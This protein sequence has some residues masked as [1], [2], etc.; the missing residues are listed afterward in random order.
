ML[1]TLSQLPGNPAD[2]VQTADWTKLSASLPA[3]RTAA[4]VTELFYPNQDVDQ[5]AK[6]RGGFLVMLDDGAYRELCERI[7][8]TPALQ[9]I[10]I[11][12]LFRTS[13]E[14]GRFMVQILGHVVAWL[15]P[16]PT[17][18]LDRRDNNKP[19]LRKDLLPALQDC[20]SRRIQAAEKRLGTFVWGS[21][22]QRG[23]DTASVLLQQEV[24]N[25]ARDNIAAFK[26]PATKQYFD[27]L[28]GSASGQQ[29]AQRF[30]DETWGGVLTIVREFLGDDFQP[31]WIASPPDTYSSRETGLEKQPADLIQSL[32]ALIR[33]SPE[34]VQ[35]PALNT[36]RASS[37]LEAA[38]VRWAVQQCRLA[39]RDWENGS[40]P[41]WPADIAQFVRSAQ[42]KYEKLLFG[43]TDQSIR[44]PEQE[45]GR[46]N[47]EDNSDSEPAD[48]PVRDSGSVRAVAGPKTQPVAARDEQ[49][50]LCKPRRPLPWR[51]I[52]RTKLGNKDGRVAQ[53]I[54]GAR[55][56]SPAPSPSQESSGD[57]K[58]DGQETPGMEATAVFADV[59]R[60]PT[61]TSRPSWRQGPIAV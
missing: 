15:N 18:A 42:H 51:K 11:Q 27:Q 54:P 21:E 39:R 46:L 5:A 36:T 33:N 41:S 55:Q 31:T 34:V 12:G 2:T 32:C 13:K 24:L 45:G 35:N 49:E 26:S 1:C 50:Y 30:L 28:P 20:P 52:D 25:F 3:N 7:L 40:G 10:D 43:L 16:N 6:R 47:A 37:A 60:P 58:P 61:R 57:Q 23:A 56:G 44:Q 59:P 9:F 48:G 8:N 53:E 38:V 19:P 29:Y 22:I 14:D 17:A 4:Q